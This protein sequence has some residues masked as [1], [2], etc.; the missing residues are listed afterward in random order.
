MCGSLHMST[1][2]YV[3]HIHSDRL[4]ALLTYFNPKSNKK[5]RIHN[6]RQLSEYKEKQK[7]AR[8]MSDHSIIQK[9]CIFTLREQV[10]DRS[11]RRVRHF[12]NNA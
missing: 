4:D 12:R 9:L 2:I 3:L 7:I 8:D 11:R 6:P 10:Q 1:S 5:R